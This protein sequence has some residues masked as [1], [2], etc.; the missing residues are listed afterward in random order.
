MVVDSNLSLIM[1]SYCVRVTVNCRELH[2]LHHWQLLITSSHLLWIPG[3]SIV[4]DC[5]L[6]YASDCRQLLTVESSTTA[7]NCG[8]CVSIDCKQLSHHWLRTPSRNQLQIIVNSVGV[9]CRWLW[10][11]I[12]HQLWTVA[13]V[14]PPSI[15]ENCRF[16]ISVNC[17]QLLQLIVGSVS[18][19]IADNCWELQIL[20]H[21]QLQTIADSWV[22]HN[23]NWL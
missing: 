12:C 4:D 13:V 5:S 16:C 19:L 3:H 1:N 14:E 6:Q 15:A 8:L 20:H 23:C 7:I 2:I 21:C 9:N 11:S 10:S 22:I 17:R 18:L